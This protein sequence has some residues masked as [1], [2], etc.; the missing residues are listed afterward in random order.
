[1]ALDDVW[2]GA[3]RGADRATAR[4]DGQ[5]GQHRDAARDRY[6]LRRSHP[7]PQPAATLARRGR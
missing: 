6:G 5:R 7:P 2:A 1:M 4:L 3:E